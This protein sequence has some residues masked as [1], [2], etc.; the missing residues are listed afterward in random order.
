AIIIFHFYIPAR[1]DRKTAIPSLALL[2]LKATPLRWSRALPG[3]KKQ[4]KP[5]HDG[6]R[7]QF[8][9]PQRVSP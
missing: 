7:L 8:L 9:Y 3:R 4:K 1:V 6:A 5:P 2:A